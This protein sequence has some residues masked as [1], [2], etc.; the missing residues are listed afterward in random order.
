V[1]KVVTWKGHAD[2]GALASQ[3]VRLRFVMRG[4]KLYAF[5]FV[6]RK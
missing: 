1:E 6:G 4:V 5:Q 3:P 2:I